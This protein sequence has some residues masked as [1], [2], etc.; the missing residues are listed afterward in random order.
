MHV[1]SERFHL[2]AALVTLLLA[3]LSPA[4]AGDLAAD[5]ISKES[6]VAEINRQRA[7]WGL[8]PLRIDDRLDLAAEDRIADMVAIG[9][10]GHQCPEGH[11]P[12]VTLESHDYRHRIAGENLA[13]GY[14]T[15]MIL[16]QSWMESPG[17]RANI[18]SSEFS[19]IGVALIEGGT[20]RRMS[21]RS[22]VVI[23][24]R[25]LDEDARKQATS[26]PH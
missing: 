10:W 6:V 23:F 22:V 11:S 13:A 25:E 4:A 12:F 2:T 8:A 7:D 20:T 21:G 1:L 24:A 3:V 16:V 18:L 26:S 9:Y 14:E 17:H 19:D 5:D 15:T